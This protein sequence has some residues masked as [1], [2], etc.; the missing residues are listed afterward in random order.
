VNIGKNELVL[1]VKQTSREI[2]LIRLGTGQM[3][4]KPFLE[5][6]RKNICLVQQ[7]KPHQKRLKPGWSQKCI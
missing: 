2:A 1:H 3:F 7:R 6:G 5:H 4:V